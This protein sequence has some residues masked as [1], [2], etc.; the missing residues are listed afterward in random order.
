QV[1]FYALIKLWP[2]ARM[3]TFNLMTAQPIVTKQ[4]RR[5]IRRARWAKEGFIYNSD[6][7]K[8]KSLN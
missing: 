7:Y 5:D 2:L 6:D 3:V 8:Y 4:Q 1:L